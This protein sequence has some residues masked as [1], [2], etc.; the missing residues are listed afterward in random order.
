MTHYR[1]R[2][3]HQ[4]ITLEG[5]PQTVINLV[6]KGT[7]SSVK[8]SV[9]VKVGTLPG[10]AYPLVQHY[11]TIRNFEIHSFEGWRKKVILGTPNVRLFEYIHTT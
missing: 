9:S 7:P 10:N 8:C 11:S 3:V 4:T 6:P 1:T 2:V 5:I